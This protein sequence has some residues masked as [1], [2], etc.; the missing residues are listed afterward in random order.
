M[1]GA[2]IVLGED[3]NVTNIT[4]AGTLNV[5]PVRARLMALIYG[6]MQWK[7]KAAAQAA[8]PHSPPPPFP[9]P[10]ASPWVGGGC[11]LPASWRGWGLGGG[12]YWVR[13]ESASNFIK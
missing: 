9:A 13:V 2:V 12:Q 7:N 4:N 6:E 5:F 10:A 11:T 1:S 8:A 3:T